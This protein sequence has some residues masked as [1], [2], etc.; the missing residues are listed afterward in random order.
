MR[1]SGDV[2]G[3]CGVGTVGYWEFSSCCTCIS[4]RRVCGL[5]CVR[6]GRRMGSGWRN[7]SV[8]K[9]TVLSKE[10]V[11]CCTVPWLQRLAERC[12]ASQRQRCRLGAVRALGAGGAGA[13]STGR[14]CWPRQ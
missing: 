9:F 12:F 8:L 6:S 3:S 2:S 1:E 11:V 14:R 13:V 4:D 7:L 5:V 10:R